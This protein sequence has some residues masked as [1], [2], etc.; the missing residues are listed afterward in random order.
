MRELESSG[1]VAAEGGVPRHNH[2]LN[3]VPVGRC[4]IRKRSSRKWW[5]RKR[6]GSCACRRC[7]PQRA[8]GS[9]KP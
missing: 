5:S 7:S 9:E 8:L 3:P 2:N 1:A 4:S 6:R